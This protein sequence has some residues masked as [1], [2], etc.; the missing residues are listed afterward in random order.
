M[1]DPKH[2]NLMK[3]IRITI[4]GSS[5][6]CP[7]DIAF[8]DRIS[9]TPHSIEYTYKPYYQ[10]EMNRPRKWFYK[11]D[12]PIFAALYHQVETLLPRYLDSDEKLMYKDLG[13]TEIIV[14]YEDKSRRT[15]SW[16]CPSVWFSELF[17]VI[18]KMVPACEDVPEVLVTNENEEE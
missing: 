10:S 6:Y 11:T 18:K 4:K 2:G 12:S 17:A 14:T 13:I 9:L 8:Q 15:E 5:G 16:C 3:I 7:V 1:S